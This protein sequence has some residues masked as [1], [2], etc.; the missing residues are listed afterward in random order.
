MPQAFGWRAS[1]YF[2]TAFAGCCEVLFIFFPDTWRKERSRVY[3]KAME[4]AVKRAMAHD[5]SAEKKRAKKAALGLASTAA[6]P[7]TTTPGTPVRRDSV[8]VDAEQGAVGVGS[9][10]VGTG[11]DPEVMLDL[12]QKEVVVKRSWWRFGRKRTEEEHETIRPSVRD[13]NPL[14]TMA[15]IFKR[16]TNALILFSS[17]E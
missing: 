14:P 1:F 7:A 4:R 10:G 6:T 9:V 16:P 2:L 15:S 17:G 13:V 11:R 3:Q 8:G 12:E 5:A